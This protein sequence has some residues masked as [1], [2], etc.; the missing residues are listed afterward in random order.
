MPL[1]EELAKKYS[2][3]GFTLL[4]I[5]TENKKSDADAMLKKIPVTFP[6]LYDNQQVVSELYKVDAM[7]SSIFIDCD[8]NLAYLH[9]GYKDGDMET[10]TKQVKSLLAS[11]Y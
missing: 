8:G 9:R 5:N 1:L 2:P 3:M 6:V 11:C 10:Y 4:S 7:P